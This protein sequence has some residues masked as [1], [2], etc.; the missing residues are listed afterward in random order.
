MKSVIKTSLVL[1]S[2]LIFSYVTLY[3][4]SD[5]NPQR[6]VSL[7]PNV[8]EIIYGLGAWDKIVGVTMYSDF[9]PEADA[10]PKVGG[11][12]NPNLEAIVRLKPDLVIFMTDQDSI[13]GDNI[14]KL[15]LNTLAVDSNKSIKDIQNSILQ[16]GKVLQKEQEAENLSNKI[17]SNFEEISSKTSEVPKKRV[18]FVVGRNPG[19]LE[20][21][22]VIGRDNY[23]NEL[24]NLAGGENV[25]KSNRFALKIAKDAILSFDPQVIIETTYDKTENKGSTIKTWGGLKEI[26]AVKNNEVHVVSSSEL[27]R[28][29]QRIIEGAYILAHILHPEV[30]ERYHGATKAQRHKE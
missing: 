8:T 16:L 30:F 22:Y 21:I 15:G 25:V 11:W 4:N 10:V 18:L 20:D 2:I 24:I 29:S 27:L 19:T 13:F 12:V 9:P 23:I 1:F 5:K 7:S 26:S 6:I 14:R 3:A 28:P 17:N